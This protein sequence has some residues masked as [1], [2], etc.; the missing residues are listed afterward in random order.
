MK[1][2]I[3]RAQLFTALGRV[4]RIVERRNTVPVLANIFMESKGGHLLLRATDM[5][6]DISETVIC[7]CEEEGST[8]V[9]AYLF[10]DIV[11]KL[12]EGEQVHLHLGAQ[13]KELYITSANIKFSLPCLNPQEFPVLHVY[14]AEHKFSLDSAAFKKLL[15]CTQ[16]SMSTEETRFYLNGLYL[17]SVKNAEGCFLRA[18][19]TDGHR[20]AWAQCAMETPLESFGVIMPRKTVNEL[21]RLL[22]ETLDTTLHLEL[23]SAY[24]RFTL[25]QVVFNSK[26]IDGEFPP[27]EK[28]IPQ[29][30]QFKFFALRA[31]LI[32]AVDRVATVAMDRNGAVKFVLKEGSLLLTARNS[33]SSSAEEQVPINYQ[34]EAVDIGFNAKY[35]LDVMNNLAEKEVEF[36]FENSSSATLIHAAQDKNV[37]Y[38]VMPVRV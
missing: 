34:G 10:Y 16:S 25:G 38:V 11:R 30:E 29:Q 27:Y 33:D 19:S 35:L 20:L 6:I 28:M 24:I 21:Q 36:H 17:N 8:T 18:V 31:E 23:S 15:D 26:L 1:V 7:T 14:P 13:A 9:P 4:H 5:D 12:P 2:M 22:S 32:R 3:E 37:L